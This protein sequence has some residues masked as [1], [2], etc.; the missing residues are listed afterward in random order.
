MI[1]QYHRM[2]NINNNFHLKSLLLVCNGRLS[3]SGA[4]IKINNTDIDDITIQCKNHYSCE[5]VTME[6][7]NVNVKNIT[8]ICVEERACNNMNIEISNLSPNAIV[9]VYCIEQL[10][11]L[12]MNMLLE[13]DE[14]NYN[15]TVGCYTDKSCDELY[16]DA[17]DEIGFGMVVHKYSENINI[18]YKKPKQLQLFC[19]NPKDK[20]FIRYET[21]CTTLLEDYQIAILAEK[22]YSANR[23]PCDDIQID[24]SERDDY[25]QKCTVTYE[26]NDY[27][28]SKILIARPKEKHPSCYWLR[29]I[30]PSLYTVTCKGTCGQ[31]QKLFNHTILFRLQIAFTSQHNFTATEVCEEFF[32]NISDTLDTLQTMNVLFNIALKLYSHHS[33]LQYIAK[34]PQ[35]WLFD[36]K[37]LIYDCQTTNNIVKVVSHFIISSKYKKKNIINPL[38][39]ADSEFAVR[40]KELMSELF[41][42]NAIMAVFDIKKIANNIY[43]PLYA[44]TVFI[45]V[46]LYAINWIRK[47]KNAYVMDKVLVLIIGV[48]V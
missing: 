23:L 38:F 18:K 7:M 31:T 6:I 42:P 1:S 2:N 17:D 13:S 14:H 4:T 30:Y 16:I 9:E 24:C 5:D 3:C 19:K 28:Q 27:N 32:G 10:S 35:T 22:E 11:C 29:D 47:Y 41:G 45:F 15:A 43:T 21:T 46:I 36:N 34:P 33:S 25:I 8:I 40:S 48:S 12:N 39:D 20:R 26:I 37:S 44:L